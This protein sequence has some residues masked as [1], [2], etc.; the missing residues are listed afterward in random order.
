[1]NSGQGSKLPRNT[2]E[3]LARFGGG[4]FAFFAFPPEEDDPSQVILGQTSFVEAAQTPEPLSLLLLGSG[5]CMLVFR[6]RTRKMAA[7]V[8]FREKLRQPPFYRAATS[9]AD[10]AP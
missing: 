5:T 1:M 9:S 8:I 4:P 6:G 2:S 10:F 3:L 7:A